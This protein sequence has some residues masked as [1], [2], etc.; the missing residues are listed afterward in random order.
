MTVACMHT[1]C[2]LHKGSG[3]PLISRAFLAGS[4]LQFYVYVCVCVCGRG[5]QGKEGRRLYF[6]AIQ[7]A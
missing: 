7:H 6:S 3:T 1:L 5:K 4:R 2:M